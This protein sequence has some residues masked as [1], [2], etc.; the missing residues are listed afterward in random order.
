MNWFHTSP[1]RR[2]GPLPPERL[3]AEEEKDW[4]L[5]LLDAEE[6]RA[7]DWFRL[8]YTARWTAETMLLSR[9]SARRL[10][11]AVFRKL[12]AA[13]ETEVL[14]LYRTAALMPQELFEE[15]GE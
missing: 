5:S 3:T 6:R 11:G 14:R 15:K 4:R 7:F 13:D 8:G 1:A 10:F 12:N 2:S 9:R